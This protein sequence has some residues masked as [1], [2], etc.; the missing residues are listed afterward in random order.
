MKRLTP[1]LLA[2]SA[3]IFSHSAKAQPV[4][5]KTV[6][7][8]VVSIQLDANKRTVISLPLEQ[9]AVAFG[10]VTS[11]S[12]NTISD[13]ASEFSNFGTAHFVRIQNGNAQGRIL[14]ILSNTATSLVV[15]TGIGNWALPVDSSSGNTVN[16]AVGD[17][18]EVIP[19]WTLGDIFGTNTATSILKTATNPNQADQVVIYSDGSQNSFFNNGT[20]WRN[21]GNPG[22][23]TNYNSLGVLPTSGL[24]ITRRSNSTNAFL[25]LIGNVPDIAPRYQLP[26]GAKFA[27]SIP[28]PSNATLGS[29]G[30]ADLSS[31]NKSNNPN[32][33]DQVT[34]YRPDNT[35][36]AY[37][38]NAAGLWRNAGN[39]GD[40]TN[41]TA[42]EI[43]AGSG[44]FVTRRGS[45][46]GPSAN[47]ASTLPYN[48][49]N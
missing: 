14:R 45:A 28:I 46:T 26:G 15:E 20:N 35:F 38:V 16:V 44:L 23:T 24:G 29:L 25:D 12:S 37:F 3:L 36:N 49:N 43:P 41:Y 8:G 40:T 18:F 21:A 4:E 2:I 11:V 27:Q 7:V 31:W 33:A 34:I 48:L 17:K 9:G 32:S 10:E 19:M 6:P 30:F 42:V 5:A 22:D 1:I 13:A 47:A 39:P